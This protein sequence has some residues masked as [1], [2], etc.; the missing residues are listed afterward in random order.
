[1][2]YFRVN[3]TD[4]S[5]GGFEFWGYFALNE[6]SLSDEELLDEAISLFEENN[7]WVFVMDCRRTSAEQLT[8]EQYKTGI[9]F[10]KLFEY[11]HDENAYRRF[12]NLYPT[13]DMAEM[14]A[15]RDHKSG[16]VRIGHPNCH[17]VYKVNSE[18]AF[19]FVYHYWSDRLGVL[20]EPPPFF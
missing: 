3:E 5:G 15:K 20:P 19:I 6:Y 9:L 7:S 8:E 12:Y 18:G 11:K 17:S 2:K 14:F 13:R 4:A 16:Y 10:N 1:M